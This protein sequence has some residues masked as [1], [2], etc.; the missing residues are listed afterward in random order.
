M[1]SSWLITSNGKT[2]SYSIPSSRCLKSFGEYPRTWSNWSGSGAE[3]DRLRPPHH[4]G[5]H[6]YRSAFFLKH[7]HKF[8]DAP[9]VIER[10]LKDVQAED[11]VKA[12]SHERRELRIGLNAG[13]A[14]PREYVSRIVGGDAAQARP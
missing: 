7:A 5:H 11:A 1:A 2:S 13:M 12:P 8:G 14:A 3:F 9:A 6:D 10:V 4:E